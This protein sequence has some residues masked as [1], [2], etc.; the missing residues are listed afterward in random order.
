[1][2]RGGGEERRGTYIS[3]SNCDGEEEEDEDEDEDE[4]ENEDEDED[5]EEEGE[6]D[7]EIGVPRFVTRFS[8]S[9]R[10]LRVL[11]HPIVVNR[12]AEY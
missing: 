2:G 1:M 11:K 5:E 12:L 6:D 8:R 9:L 7:D 3:T 4:D 10:A